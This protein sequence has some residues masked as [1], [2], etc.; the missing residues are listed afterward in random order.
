MT[1]PHPPS[2]EF[3]EKEA[4]QSAFPPVVLTTKMMILGPYP[5]Y[6]V[7]DRVYIE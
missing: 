6:I 3:G 4:S 7:K 1:Y 5:L 2:H